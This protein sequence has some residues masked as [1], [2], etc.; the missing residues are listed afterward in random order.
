MK[1][2]L[3]AQHRMDSFI[4]VC[5]VAVFP[6][7]LVRAFLY[8]IMKMFLLACGRVRLSPY[9]VGIGVLLLMPGS[10][11]L[12]AHAQPEGDS[13]IVPDDAATGVGVTIAPVETLHKKRRGPTGK[14]KSAT[15]RCGRQPAWNWAG[16][17]G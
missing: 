1:G 4:C 14:S 7:Q 17:M 3:K 9:L 10:T 5:N 2:M 13:L 15:G 16:L 12:P 6:A 11:L 8:P